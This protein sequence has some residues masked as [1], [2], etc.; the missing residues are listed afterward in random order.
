MRLQRWVVLY[1]LRAIEKLDEN[2][3]LGVSHRSK[4]EKRLRRKYLREQRKIPGNRK[5][6]ISS[7]LN[8][9]ELL[10]KVISL[11]FQI[12]SKTCA[13]NRARFFAREKP[14]YITVS[15]SGLL[16]KDRS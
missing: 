13:R 3:S 6:T 15:E 9:L 4:E 8:I 12:S 2:P 10:L 1:L 14:H 5:V 11:V 16:S 7:V